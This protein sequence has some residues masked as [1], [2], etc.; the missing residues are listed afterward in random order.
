MTVSLQDEVVRLEGDC[1]V[2]DAETLS[3]LLDGQGGRVVDVGECRQLH[4][5][6]LQALLHYRPQLIGAC[7]NRFLE[8]WAFRDLRSRKI[9]D[10]ETP[11]DWT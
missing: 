8:Q 5:A 6:V 3:A 1:R 11:R 4:T 2:E 7:G 9:E 10:E